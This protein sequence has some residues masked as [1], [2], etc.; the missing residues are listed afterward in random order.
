MEGVRTVNGLLKVGY[1]LTLQRDDNART[2]ET[3]KSDVEEGSGRYRNVGLNFD[4]PLR[5]PFL[6]ERP[7]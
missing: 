6:C 7:T 5:S 4:Q 2:G 1:G 3:G